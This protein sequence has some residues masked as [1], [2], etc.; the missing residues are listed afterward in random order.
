LEKR[1]KIRP[2]VVKKHH[3]LELIE[4]HDSLRILDENTLRRHKKH[5]QNQSFAQSQFT[6]EKYFLIIRAK[7]VPRKREAR[8]GFTRLFRHVL[9]FGPADLRFLQLID[10]L[11]A[12]R[13]EAVVETA[14]NFS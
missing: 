1:A 2:G 13:R 5:F 11:E 7:H 14:A 12:K 4:C 6:T 3:I 8:I 10:F 9:P